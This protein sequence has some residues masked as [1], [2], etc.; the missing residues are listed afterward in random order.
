MI[1]VQDL[2]FTKNKQSIPTR[3]L[4]INTLNAGNSK[5]MIFNSKPNPS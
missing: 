1:G 4:F 5:S 3:I 2:A